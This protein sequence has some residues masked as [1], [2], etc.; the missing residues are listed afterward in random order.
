MT[1]ENAL[2]LAAFEPDIPQNTGAFMRL[3][4]GFDMGLEIIEPCG[5]IWDE[6]KIKQSALDYYHNVRLTR[7]TSWERF[8]ENLNGRRIILLTNKGDPTP[9][10]GFAFRADDILLVGRESAG[11]PDFVHNQADARLIIPMSPHIRSFN[12]AM[13]AAIVAGEAMRQL[14]WGS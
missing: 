4:A 14:G 13:A 7:H 9:Y 10:T 6:R 8:L 12:V 5:F 3:C 2:S 11:V 1:K